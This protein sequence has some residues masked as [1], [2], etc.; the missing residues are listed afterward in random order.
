[1]LLAV[2]SL[3]LVWYFEH[4]GLPGFVKER[5]L[6]NLRE[7]GLV[8]DFDS[9]RWIPSEGVLVENATLVGV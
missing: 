1:M 4:R 3:S 8:I 9:M 5:I 7:K 2:L 6:D